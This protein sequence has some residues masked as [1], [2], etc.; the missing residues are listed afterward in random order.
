[1]LSPSR[2]KWILTT[3]GIIFLVSLLCGGVT[4]Y[5]HG[6]PL[7]VPMRDQLYAGVVYRR[8]VR[9]LPRLMMIHILTLDLHT[10]GIRFMVTPP[11]FSNKRAEY[12]LKARTTSHFLEE[13]DVQIAV[14]GD[15]FFPWYTNSP[16]D[17]YPHSNDPVTPNGFA[18]S[19]GKAYS[20]GTEPTMYISRRNVVTFGES[21]GKPFNAISGDRMLVMAGKPVKGLDDQVANPRTAVGLSRDG[22]VLILVVVDGRQPFYSQGM[23]FAELADLLISTGAYTAMNL[24]G[25]GSSTMAVA[26]SDGLAR[27]LNS[28]V[29]AHIPGRERPVANHLGIF[30]EE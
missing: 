16:L 3:L 13:Y 22:K 30:I 7:P 15:G 29:D 4:L 8:Q 25:G 5:F 19:R 10:R 20:S 6:R 14:N 9:L 11:D 18:A 1:M 12:P 28:P 24:D 17:Y 27:V 26:G 2:H 21:R 23:T